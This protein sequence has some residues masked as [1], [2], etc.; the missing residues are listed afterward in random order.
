MKKKRIMFCIIF[1]IVVCIQT[2]CLAADS[3]TAK[4]MENEMLIE[5]TS[6]SEITSFISSVLTVVLVGGL[7]FAIINKILL[8]SNKNQNSD[9][10]KKKNSAYNILILLNI[11]ALVIKLNLSAIHSFAGSFE[12][13]GF[14]TEIF[15]NGIM[16]IIIVIM[17]NVY[18]RINNISKNNKNTLLKRIIIIALL[19]V[20][21]LLIYSI[22]TG[23]NIY[24]EM[25]G[26]FNLLDSMD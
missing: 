1:I 21:L 17:L 24:K 12:I 11:I 7:A 5:Y 9:D 18:L 4:Q 25:I 23:F 20:A 8:K 3:L 10:F 26:F 16:E 19:I 13:S 14:F 6:M 22:I 15:C 2:T